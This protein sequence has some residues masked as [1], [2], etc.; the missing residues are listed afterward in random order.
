MISL[1]IGSESAERALKILKSI[2]EILG[3]LTPGSRDA[4]L[5]MAQRGEATE[6][7]GLSTSYNILQDP[8][9]LSVVIFFQGAEHVK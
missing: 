4:S 8:K 1:R 7:I 2:F 5:V 3:P 9:Y 6:N